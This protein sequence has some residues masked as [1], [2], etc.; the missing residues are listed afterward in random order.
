MRAPF[1]KNR[2]FYKFCLYGFFKNLKF[3]EPFFLLFF[4]TQGLSFLEIGGLYSIRQLTIFLMEIPTGIVADSLGR[5]RTIIISFGL[6]IVS[7][8]VF[9]AFHTYPFFI[10]GMLLFSLA[11]ASRSGTHKAMILEYLRMQG[12]E[13]YRIDYYGATRSC[14]QKGSAVSALIAA[15]IVFFSNNYEVIFLFS[16]IPLVIN[17]LLVASYP[18]EVDGTIRKKRFLTNFKQQF[19]SL[20]ASL[21]KKKTLFIYFAIASFSGYY[22]ESKDYIQVIIKSFAITVP[23]TFI[24]VDNHQKSTMFI[25][26]IFFLIY[27]LTSAAS[28]NAFKV[29]RMFTDKM[30]AL[31]SLLV[32]GSIMGLIAGILFYFKYYWVSLLF[33]VTIYLIENVRKPIGV[34]IIADNFKQKM[35]ATNLSVESFLK[36][37]IS[38]GVAMGMGILADHFGVGMALAI[39]SA[40]LLLL[41]VVFFRGMKGI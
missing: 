15:A 2:Q 5:K 7:F 36:T 1:P 12:L 4:I 24:A 31:N 11:D 21:Q 8:L 27:L 6:Y 41:S 26:V 23:I 19:R 25:G 29:N 9:F 10:L 20:I 22:K 37:I 18:K 13:K 28:K 40:L 32:I 14:S 16:I 34:A 35:M 30:L 33:F 3:F 39:I 38:T 17:M